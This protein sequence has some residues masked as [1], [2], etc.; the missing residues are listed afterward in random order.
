[1][2]QKRRYGEDLTYAE[3]HRRALPELYGRIGHRLDLADR[4]WTEFCHFCKRP[5]ALYEEV[6]DKGQNLFDKAAT[7]VTR[8]V[9][10]LARLDAFLLA[11][12]IERPRAVDREIEELNRRLRV[13]EAAW[14]ITRISVRQLVP[15]RDRHFESM[16]PEWWRKVL[17]MHRKHHA[18]CVLAR[19][20]G[21]FPV[22]RDRLAAAEEAHPLHRPA[23]FDVPGW[24][25]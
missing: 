16:P 6:R 2:S 11:W 18:D 17:I 24:S 3:E 20:H 22:R 19:K 15:V 1:M 5:L 8:N 13:L 25:A 10:G 7:T 4:D 23:L 9:A 21:E 14:P 12:A